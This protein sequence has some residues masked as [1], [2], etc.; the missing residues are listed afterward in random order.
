[1]ATVPMTITPE[2]CIA[3]RELTEPRLD[4]DG[5]RVA[6]VSRGSDGAAI[7]VVD[8]AVDGHAGPERTLTTAP[9]PSPGRGRDGGCFTWT[10]DGAAVVYAATDGGLW[11]Q[12]AVGGPPTP[13]VVG[14]TERAGAAPA[15]TPDG[16]AVVYLVD[17][18]EVWTASLAGGEPRR[19]DDGGHDFCFDPVVGPSG[20]TVAYQ[21]WRVPDMAWDG[22]EIV[23]V[24]LAGGWPTAWRPDDGAAQQPRFSPDGTLV[25]VH[26]GSGWLNVWWGER[27]LVD[28]A[29]EHAEPSWGP[30]QASYAI[31]PDGSAVAFTRN[32]RG[33]GRLGVVDVAGGEV[34]EVARGVHGALSWR[35]DR[36]AALRSGAR[37][38][39]E[40][41][42]YDTSTWAR[43]TI[44][45]GP[46]L[47]WEHAVLPEPELVELA[48]DGTVLHARRY[49]SGDGADRL[50]VW[51]HGGPT[52]QWAVTF[53]PDLAY[54]MGQ[55]WD[56]LVPDHRGSTGHGRAYQQA[57]RRRWGELDVIDTVAWLAH[58]VA[59]GWA[60]PERTVLMGGSA[61]GFTLLGVLAAHPGGVAGAVAAYPVTDL[62][63]LAA[64]SHRFEAH[65]TITLVGPLEQTERYAARS[66]LTYVDRIDAPLLLLHGTDDPVVP[67]EGTIELA[68]R[69][70]SAGRDVELHL[71]DG[72]GHG[73]RQP[74]NKLEEL[75]VIGAF[76]HRVVES[77]GR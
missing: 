51:L 65:Y 55:G 74:A 61:G 6:F 13:L 7:V 19:L 24:P 28:E 39:T 17:Q 37:T 48:H 36:L 29:F 50:L 3:G 11:R 72:E 58:A 67:V 22:A 21:A 46:V 49:R 76:L 71:F 63:E 52:S 60:P 53:R 57:L 10:P 43:R 25:A 27:P 1:M 38:P 30:G 32:E 69:L 31:A 54:W 56:V 18:A 42:V 73:F 62:A 14:S 34:R 75:R 45:V 41:V 44:A 33:F 64:H 26:D 66:P 8:L 59:E 12:P 35:G 15:M 9:P 77:R 23:T 68:S 16:T 2:M 4:P 47:G 40:V 70:R 20:T 5:R